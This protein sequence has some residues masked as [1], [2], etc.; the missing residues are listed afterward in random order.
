M[1]S[2]DTHT[3][4][5]TQPATISRCHGNPE[6][7]ACQAPA[8]SWC[9]LK[10]RHN[11]TLSL[12]KRLCVCVSM[13]STAILLNWLLFIFSFF[14]GEVD[15]GLQLQQVYVNE[16]VWT[17]THA[18]TPSVQNT[19]AVDNVITELSRVKRPASYLCVTGA[20]RKYGCWMNSHLLKWQLCG[21]W[22]KQSIGSLSWGSATLQPNMKT[23]YSTL[24]HSVLIHMDRHAHCCAVLKLHQW[25]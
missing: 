23:I 12:L 3:H 7:V 9:Y 10:H 17:R 13:Q 4:T 11:H 20:R 5:H 14:S 6:Q 18:C 25:K 22:L 8:F 15:Q 19:T 16:R 21:I 2:Q 1:S 24:N